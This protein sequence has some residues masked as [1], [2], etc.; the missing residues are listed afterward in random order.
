MWRCSS[1]GR[2]LN[3]ATQRKV[4]WRYFERFFVSVATFIIVFLWSPKAIL[5][6]L[7]N[8]LDDRIFETRLREARSPML[9]SLRTWE[10]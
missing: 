1:A 3:L 4:D 5:R 7:R 2:W 10:R 9:L 8:Y 6:Q